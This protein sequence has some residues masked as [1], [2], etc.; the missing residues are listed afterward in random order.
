MATFNPAHTPQDTLGSY[1]WGQ[2]SGRWGSEES[3]RSWANPSSVEG[4]FV[5][6]AWLASAPSSP[7]CSAPD[8]APIISRTSAAWRA[9]N[10]L[11]ARGVQEE[12][13]Q[14]GGRAGPRGAGRYEAAGGPDLH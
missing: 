5:C 14:A 1:L 3:F 7:F 2:Q 10:R 4:S 6:R 11:G 12:P 8:L 9:A 13:G